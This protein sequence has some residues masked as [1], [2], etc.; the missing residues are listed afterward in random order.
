MNHYYYSNITLS[1]RRCKGTTFFRYRLYQMFRFFTFLNIYH[2][3]CEN[4][5]I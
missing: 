4:A 2:F 1:Y 3:F 5:T